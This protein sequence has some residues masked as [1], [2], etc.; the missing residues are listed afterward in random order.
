MNSA[1]LSIALIALAAVSIAP[2]LLPLPIEKMNYPDSKRTDHTD[3]YFGT[4]VPDPYRWLEEENSPDTK[5]GSMPKT[6]YTFG[7]LEKIPYR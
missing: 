4:P 7:Y 5:R 6:K 1:Y 2:A 3:T